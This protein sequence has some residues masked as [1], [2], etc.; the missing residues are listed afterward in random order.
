V[1]HVALD[2]ARPD[3]RDLDHQIIEAAR[4]ES[5]QGIHLRAALHL[6]HADRVGGAQVVVHR[7]VVHRQRREVDGHPAPLSDVQ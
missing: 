2:R 3:D 1:H 7:L 5:R 6:E 4:L